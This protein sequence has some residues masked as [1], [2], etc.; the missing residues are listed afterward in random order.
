MPVDT[1]TSKT[2]AQWR[3][4]LLIGYTMLVTY[5]MLIGLGRE[6]LGE[7]RYNFVPFD[8]IY[9][10]LI[11]TGIN[12]FWLM[13][14]MGNIVL[15]IPFGILLPLIWPLRYW[16]V[17]LIHTLGICV[18]EAMQLLT[19]RGMLDI[20]DLI[21]NTLGMTIGYAIYQHLKRNNSK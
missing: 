14:F 20:D 17:L 21:L 6:M 13:R 3:I 1:T 4:I 11:T 2:Q 9:H 8:S 10:D 5:G 12:R 15:F 18:L 7:Y 16:Q 19:Q